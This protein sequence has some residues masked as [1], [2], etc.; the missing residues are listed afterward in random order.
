[1]DRLLS[2]VGYIGG[3]ADSPATYHKLGETLA[4]VSPLVLFQQNRTMG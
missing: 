3:D 2:S 4:D 1:V